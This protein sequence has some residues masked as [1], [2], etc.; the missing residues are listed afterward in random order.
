MNSLNENEVPEL[1]GYLTELS[2]GEL[3]KLHTALNSLR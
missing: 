3:T 2:D 1:Q